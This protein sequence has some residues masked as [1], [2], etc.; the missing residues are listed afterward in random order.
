MK[1]TK[2][3]N[4]EE[5]MDARRGRI[6]GSRVKDVIIK[7]KGAADKMGYFEL[8]AERL[9]LPSDGENPMERGHRLEE[10]AVAE[11]VKETGKK[12][13]TD[14]VIWERD[15]NSRIALSPDGYM[16]DEKEAVEVK[17]LKSALHIK[18]YILQEIP[19]DYDDQAIQYFVVNEKLETLY[20]AFY[21]PLLSVKTSFHIT[22]TREQMQDKVDK[23]LADQINLL[24]RVDAEVNK[25]T[26]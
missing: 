16:E 2:Y 6:T 23:Y 26:F 18:A 4:T 1:I 20:F 14:L 5:W 10:F 19:K 15:D 22:I 17:C 12:V 21:D 8:I 13:N 7:R 11:F 3:D 9:A 25:L 24:E